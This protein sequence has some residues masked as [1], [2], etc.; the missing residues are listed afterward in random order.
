LPSFRFCQLAYLNAAR[1][2]QPPERIQ[3]YK[4]WLAL[5]NDFEIHNQHLNPKK[6]LRLRVSCVAKHRWKLGSSQRDEHFSAF[7]L[8]FLSEYLWGYVHPYQYE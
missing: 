7:M 3:R 1:I 5:E 8:Q 6:T 4:N 2:S